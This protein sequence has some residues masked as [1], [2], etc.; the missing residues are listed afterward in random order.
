MSSVNHLSWNFPKQM[1]LPDQRPGWSLFHPQGLRMDGEAGKVCTWGSAARALQGR[2]CSSP[3]PPQSLISI[4][5]AWERPTPGR[6][7]PSH[8]AAYGLPVAAP[9]AALCPHLTPI[10]AAT[11]LLESPPPHTP[12]L[13]ASPAQPPLR[14]ASA[15]L[16]VP[17]PSF[18]CRSPPTCPEGPFITSPLI[19]AH[20]FYPHLQTRGPAPSVDNRSSAAP[21]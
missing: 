9:V 12:S 8:Q 15:P 14:S 5:L 6:S 17:A 13:S 16:P 7:S 2:R 4:P 18:P 1:Q 19:S 10:P 11:S 21:H 3:T 20:S